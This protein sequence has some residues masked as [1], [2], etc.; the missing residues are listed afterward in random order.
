MNVPKF[1]INNNVLFASPPFFKN[2]TAE[3]RYVIK[4]DWDL[5]IR[6]SYTYNV[7][8]PLVIGQVTTRVVRRMVVVAIFVFWLLSTTTKM[9]CHATA[10]LLSVYCMT[11]KPATPQV[12]ASHL[13]AN[14]ATV[15]ILP[16]AVLLF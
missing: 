2:D 6:S 15:Y 11:R 16:W 9:A 4:V 3:T 13:Q 8:S 7:S 14:T 1:C 12:P 5:C 10:H